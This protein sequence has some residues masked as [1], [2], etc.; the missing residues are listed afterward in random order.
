MLIKLG[1]SENSISNVKEPQGEVL[2]LHKKLA[3][4]VI[5]VFYLYLFYPFFSALVFTKIH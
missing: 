4:F 1:S 5:C 3:E 2:I